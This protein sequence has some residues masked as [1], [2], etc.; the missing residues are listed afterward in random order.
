MIYKVGDRVRIRSDLKVGTNK[1]DVYVNQ[2]MTRMA[3][4]VVT[5]QST[6]LIPPLVYKVSGSCY[7]WTELEFV[8]QVKME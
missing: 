6:F 3:G 5:I 8:N 4:R 2:D 1:L 7:N